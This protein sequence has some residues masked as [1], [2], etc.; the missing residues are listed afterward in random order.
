MPV[1]EEIERAVLM[2]SCNKTCL[3]TVGRHPTGN[4]VAVNVRSTSVIV[5]PIPIL[6]TVTVYAA[7]I[8]VRPTLNEDLPVLSDIH[9]HDCQCRF[10]ELC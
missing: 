7:L 6:N 9:R 2:A 1:H 10:L 5:T 8:P 4:A 3:R